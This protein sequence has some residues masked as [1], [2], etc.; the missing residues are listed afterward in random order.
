MRIQINHRG[1]EKSHRGSTEKAGAFLCESLC[2]L[3]ASVV[4]LFCPPSRGAV[5]EKRPVMRV[6]MMLCAALCVTL[7]YETLR[8]QNTS[9]N[10]QASGEVSSRDAPSSHASSPLNN[11][12]D[13]NVN[14]DVARRLRV[15]DAAWQAINERYYDVRLNGVAWEQVQSELRPLAGRAGS[16]EMLYLVLR[17][18]T[19][20]LR[21]AHTRVFARDEPRDWR[22]PRVRSVGLAVR[23]IAGEFVIT[24]V[25]ADSPAA[26]QGIVAGDVVRKI[27]GKSITDILTAK[28]DEANGASTPRA[29]RA[30]LV[31]Y[32]FDG[33]PDTIVKLEILDKDERPRVVSLLRTEQR[34]RIALSA[35]KINASYGGKRRT[36]AV[37]SFPGFTS[38]IAAA[39]A[40]E[41]RGSLRSVDGFILDFRGNGGGEAEAMI[42]VASLFLPPR[43]YLGRFIDRRGRVAETLETRRVMMSSAERITPDAR[44]VVVLISVRSASATEVLVAAFKENRRAKVIG[45]ATCGCVLGVRRQHKLPDGGALQISEL[46]FATPGGTRLEGK[47]IV[48]DEEVTPTR[49]DFYRKRDAAFERAVRALESSS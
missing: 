23:E 44:P 36:F 1:T 35:A 13:D 25:V 28:T 18:M 3:C 6:M 21:D 29:A 37:I 15:F 30:R 22:A 2:R 45:E 39:L 5:W 19:A 12:N 48:P 41:M 26:R 8:A 46:D 33:A 49:T 34:G 7:W 20:R 10:V 24:N 43:Q 42:D 16:D 27:D 38:D 32:L 14:T 11:S 40:R 9:H 31:A 47:G 17:R 4:N